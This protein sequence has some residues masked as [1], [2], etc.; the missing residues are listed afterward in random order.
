MSEV[1]R[2]SDGPRLSFTDEQFE[3]IRNAFWQFDDQGRLGNMALLDEALDRIGVN[4]VAQKEEALRLFALA[5]DRLFPVVLEFYSIDTNVPYA[6]W[7]MMKFALSVGSRLETE[8]DL[9]YV[10]RGFLAHIVPSE[11]MEM[12]LRKLKMPIGYVGLP[13]VDRPG[14]FDVGVF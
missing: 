10:M 6:F 4:D 13:S 14:E 3:D 11:V 2:I 8:D 7:Q 5:K 1:I 9:I 12:F